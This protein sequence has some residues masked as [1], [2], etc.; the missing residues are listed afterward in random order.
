M[1][2]F[3]YIIKTT[4]VVC[5]EGYDINKTYLYRDNAVRHCCHNGLVLL[6]H[7]HFLFAIIDSNLLAKHCNFLK[8]LKEYMKK[9]KDAV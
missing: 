8:W 4:Q 6:Y 2:W 7:K 3:Y 1:V 5:A 9:A